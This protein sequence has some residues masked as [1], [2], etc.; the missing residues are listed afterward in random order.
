MMCLEI[1]T[2]YRESHTEPNLWVQSVGKICSA[3]VKAG[4]ACSNHCALKDYLAD[5]CIWMTK[6]YAEVKIMKAGFLFM[7]VKL[8][9]A[10]CL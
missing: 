2:V 9:L 7:E 8:K 5:L 6:M 10:L 4:S 1:I 3:N